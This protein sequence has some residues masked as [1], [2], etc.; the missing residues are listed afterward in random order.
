MTD[1]AA[2]LERVERERRAREDELLLLILALMSTARRDAA[3]VLTHGG[4]PGYAIRSVVTGTNG[5]RGVA[6]LIARTMAQAHRDG[7]RRAGLMAG[8]R[9]VERADAGTLAALVDLYMPGAREA[10]AAMA[11]TLVQ[12]VYEAVAQARSEGTAGTALRRTVREAFD[13]AGYTP[14][15]DRGADL[16]TER[17]VVSAHSFGIISAAI[18]APALQGI[19]TGLE[20]RSILDSSTTDICRERHELRLPVTAAYWRTNTPSLHFRCRS[21]LRILTKPFTP[22][23]TLPQTPP[24]PG[25]GSPP[26]GF[27]EGLMRRAA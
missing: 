4:D 21:S 13:A 3:A 23:A 9:A 16:A 18:G 26:P 14:T 17:A 2:E 27:L 22:T 8:T 11:A 7:Y 25:F 1:D 24:M 20:H 12:A 5:F 15:H 19:V 6:P 10:A